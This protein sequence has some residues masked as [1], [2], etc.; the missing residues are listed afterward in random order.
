MKSVGHILFAGPYEYFR[1][2]G[3]I[4]KALTSNPIQID[5]YRHGRWEGYD[6]QQT[7]ARLEWVKQYWEEARV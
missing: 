6:R 7:V 5:G 4:Y 1:R 2:E 3:H